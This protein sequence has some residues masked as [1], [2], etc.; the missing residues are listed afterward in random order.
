[1]LPIVKDGFLKLYGA[2]NTAYTG[3]GFM[4]HS[5]FHVRKSN[6]KLGQ[7]FVAFGYIPKVGFYKVIKNYFADCPGLQEKVK[8]GELDQDD[9]IKIVDYYNENC[10]PK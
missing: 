4:N 7:Y 3:T 10:A 9:Y 2:Y 1:M 8:K 6:E 5:T